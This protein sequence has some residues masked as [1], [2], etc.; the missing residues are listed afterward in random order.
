MQ[1]PAGNQ[2]SSTADGLHSCA[3]PPENEAFTL[4]ELLVVIAVIGILAGILLPALARAKSRGNS[5][6]CLN[7]LRQFG[8]ALQMYAGDHD[9]ALPYN[10]GTEGIRRTVAAGE[11]LNWVNNVMSWELDADNTNSTL[12]ILAQR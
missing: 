5:A 7:N 11:Y 10:M 6:Y 2:T 12:L 4:V 9:D 8:L 3:R 1:A